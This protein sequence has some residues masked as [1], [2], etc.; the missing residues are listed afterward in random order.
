[1]IHIGWWQSNSPSYS[2]LDLGCG[3]GRILLELGK[4]GYTCLTGVDYSPKAI[5]LASAFS[6]DQGLPSIQ[7]KVG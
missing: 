6:V 7:W 3:N 2:I 5:E 1:M 4:K